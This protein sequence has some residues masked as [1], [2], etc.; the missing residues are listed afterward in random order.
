MKRQYAGIR[1]GRLVAIRPCGKDKNRNILWECVCDCGNKTVV[2]AASLRKTRSC[3]CLGRELIANRNYSHGR[4]DQKL[5]KVWAAIKQRCTN[6]K[7]SRFSDYGGRGINLCHEWLDFEP[8]FRWAIENGYKNG[9]EVDRI[10][11]DGGYS[12]DNCRI[13]ERKQNQRNKRD[14][15]FIEFANKRLTISD[16]AERVGTSPKTIWKR[17]Y[18]G[19]SVPSALFLPNGSHNRDMTPA[20]LDALVSRWGEV[21]A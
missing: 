10:D 8:F 5:Y 1:F 16:W 19:W 20:E 4:S 17:L 11:N 21:S 18:R 6:P 3:G 7:N 2:S 15:H 9:L 12:P 13:V 14:N